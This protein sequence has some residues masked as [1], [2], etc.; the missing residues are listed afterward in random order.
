MGFF[1]QT[2]RIYQF[3][4]SI[5]LNEFICSLNIKVIFHNY[6][7][8]S[9]IRV[10]QEQYIQRQKSNQADCLTEGNTVF[11]LPS[12]FAEEE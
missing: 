6:F 9:V 11:L 7:V 5:N 2:L 1:A 4:A 8:A 12:N 10:T 3:L